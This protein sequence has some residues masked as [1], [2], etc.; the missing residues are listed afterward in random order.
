MLHVK[1]VPLYWT[2]DDAIP[3]QG[4]NRRENG[5]HV[6]FNPYRGTSLVRNRQPFQDHD[7]ALDIT[8]WRVLGWNGFPMSEGPL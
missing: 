4:L 2:G 3:L 8:Y 5:G 1:E 7:R 6:G